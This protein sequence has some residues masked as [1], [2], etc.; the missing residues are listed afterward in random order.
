M[1]ILS[2]YSILLVY[3]SEQQLSIQALP[4]PKLPACYQLSK[5]LH[6]IKSTLLQ[7]ERKMRNI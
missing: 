4:K 2:I 7:L 1:L 3:S 6:D 5:H